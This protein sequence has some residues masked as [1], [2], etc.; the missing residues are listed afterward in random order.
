[1]TELEELKNSWQQTTININRAADK[2]AQLLDR[3]MSRQISSTRYRMI[4]NHAI[5]FA[6]CWLAPL[7]LIASSAVGL[8]YPTW[9]KVIYVLFFVIVAALQAW[10]IFIVSGIRPG[11]MTTTEAFAQTI[12][13][14]RYNNRRQ[15]ISTVLAI[16]VVGSIFYYLFETNEIEAL[17]GAWVGLVIGGIIGLLA[18]LRQRR[19]I[20]NMLDD[21]R[22]LADREE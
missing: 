15:L 8:D 18:N 17:I 4:R 21:L 9:I 2:Q 12:S 6:V 11:E 7:L 1:M 5:A 14:K 3:V 20:N 13:Y 22:S 16:G 19:A 10:G